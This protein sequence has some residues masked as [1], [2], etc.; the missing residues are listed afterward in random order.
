MS[1]IFRKF[2]FKTYQSLG[3]FKHQ[4]FYSIFGFSSKCKHTPTC[5]RYTQAQIERHGTIV[6][7]IKGLLR[8]VT[9]W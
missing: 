2:L 8:L 7:S 4:I 5:S 3:T 6:G 1:K 9:C